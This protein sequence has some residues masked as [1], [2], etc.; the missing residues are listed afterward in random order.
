MSAVES[1][2]M[3]L[4]L[5]HT[6][7]FDNQCYILIDKGSAERTYSCDNPCSHSTLST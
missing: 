7:I 4:Q 2:I 1:P 5:L 6:E 3:P